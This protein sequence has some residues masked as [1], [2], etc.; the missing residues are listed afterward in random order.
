MAGDPARVRFP[1]TKVD[2]SKDS[3]FSYPGDRRKKRVAGY[4]SVGDP[5]MK[6]D[7]QGF[8]AAVSR[9]AGRKDLEFANEGLK[10]ITNEREQRGSVSQVSTGRSEKGGKGGEK[11]VV[12]E[13]CVLVFLVPM[14]NLVLFDVGVAPGDKGRDVAQRPRKPPAIVASDLRL[15]GRHLQAGRQAGRGVSGDGQRNDAQHRQAVEYEVESSREQREAGVAKGR[16]SIR[17]SPP[18]GNQIKSRGGRR[19]FA[20][21]ASAPWCHFT[22]HLR[23]KLHLLYSVRSAP[24]G[25][26][27]DLPPEWPTTPFPSFNMER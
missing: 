10:E 15:I 16:L 26:L 24:F 12:C 6:V 9:G 21:K 1:D 7:G 8:R 3:Y 22:F 25:F 18:R 13:F 17:P 19:A 23:T 11:Q 4:R 14:Q 2:I 20:K 27:F 5:G